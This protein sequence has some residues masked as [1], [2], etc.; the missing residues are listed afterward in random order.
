VFVKVFEVLSIILISV[1]VKDREV[2]GMV[3][4][5]PQQRQ[6]TT[7]RREDLQRKLRQ[8]WRKERQRRQ[9][10]RRSRERMWRPREVRGMEKNDVREDIQHHHKDR[11]RIELE[12]KELRCIDI[13]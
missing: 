11:F 12:W 1:F 4:E 5:I 6:K 9:R 3:I 8:R 2:I 10:Q 7:K 13:D